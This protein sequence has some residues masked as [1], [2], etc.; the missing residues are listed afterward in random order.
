MICGSLVDVLCL[1][2][3]NVANFW[4]RKRTI[5]KFIFG[6]DIWEQPS[7]H[8]ESPKLQRSFIWLSCTTHPSLM[9]FGYPR[10]T[11]SKQVHPGKCPW[12]WGLQ[13][14]FMLWG[15][16]WLPVTKLPNYSITQ[17][18]LSSSPV[19]S[20]PVQ[21]NFT[22][23]SL[24]VGQHSHSQHPVCYEWECCL[25]ISEKRELI[26]GIQIHTGLLRKLNTLHSTI[27]CT[28]MISL[29]ILSYLSAFV[30]YSY[31]NSERWAGRE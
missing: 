24:I 31:M 7:S 28:A 20:S 9:E 23:L 12:G 10:Y 2:S 14:W 30:N 1:K 4:E 5:K 6:S 15:A 3:T 18:A 25:T 29:N 17:I 22:A 26:S 8:A 19:L 13:Q 11:P 27:V 16:V 21:K